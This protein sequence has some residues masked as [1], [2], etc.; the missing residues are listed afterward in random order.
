MIPP[1]GPAGKLP[2]WLVDQQ[3]YE[4]T[5]EAH[6]QDTSSRYGDQVDRPVVAD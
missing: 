2:E 1:I 3:G 4:R 5:G 6:H